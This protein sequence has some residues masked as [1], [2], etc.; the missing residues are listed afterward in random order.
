MKVKQV[1][2]SSHR[3]RRLKPPSIVIVGS[4]TI[5]GLQPG[6]ANV[7]IALGS[8]AR[9]WDDLRQHTK[10]TDDQ[11]GLTLVELLDRKLVATKT[12]R[13]GDRVYLPV[14]K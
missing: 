2:T 12:G 9:A 10:L 8:G 3:P 13:N 11:L 4:R 5:V 14:D 6:A 7:M 1:R